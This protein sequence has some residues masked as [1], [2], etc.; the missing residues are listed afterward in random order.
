MTLPVDF[1]VLWITTGIVT[2]R[3]PFHKV[4]GQHLMQC[5]HKS[6]I[7]NYHPNF[8]VTHHPWPRMV[9][10]DEQYN[11]EKPCQG[12]FKNALLLKVSKSLSLFS[13]NIYQ[14]NRHSS[15]Y[16]RHP[17]LLSSV[18]RSMVTALIVKHLLDP[19]ENGRRSLTKS[20]PILTSLRCWAWRQ[21]PHDL[22]PTLLFR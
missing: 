2:S 19:P 5:R 6:H 8:L 20:A 12:L 10:K 11:P 13:C 18:T 21:S 16:P 22:S 3:F 7:R 9:Y 17:V 15:S 1:F 4:D 14:V